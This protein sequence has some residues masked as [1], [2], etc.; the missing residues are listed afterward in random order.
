MCRL[1]G[2]TSISSAARGRPESWRGIPAWIAASGSISRSR[3]SSARV[4]TSRSA[5][6]RGTATNPPSNSIRTADE[7]PSRTG[8][9]GAADRCSD[10]GRDD[11]VADLRERTRD[12]Q[13]FTGR[14]RRPDVSR[15]ADR[16]RPGPASGAEPGQGERY[17]IGDQPGRRTEYDEQP[18]RRQAGVRRIHSS[19]AGRQMARRHV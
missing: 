6:S 11:V 19:G 13:D 8:F 5:R 10:R 4:T 2:A 17:A 9:A 16:A 1:T 3:I 18:P 15:R 7:R 12:L 14:A